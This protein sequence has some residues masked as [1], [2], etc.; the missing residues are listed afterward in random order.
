MAEMGSPLEIGRDQWRPTWEHLVGS[1]E[2]L[3]ALDVP[4]LNCYPHYLSSCQQKMDGWVIVIMT[5]GNF[6]LESKMW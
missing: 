6:T 2:E 1:M 4:A 5:A 3:G